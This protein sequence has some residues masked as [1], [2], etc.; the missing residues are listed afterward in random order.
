[1][2]NYE[3]KNENSNIGDEFVNT[4]FEGAVITE[5]G[6]SFGVVSVQRNVFQNSFNATMI[7]KAV[8]PAFNGIPVVLMTL[9]AQG[10]PAY[11]GRS[12]LVLLLENIN[13]KDASWTQIN[14]D[15]DLSNSC[16]MKEEVE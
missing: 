13:I 3:F 2:S 14:A 4:Q 9:D 5:Q 6:K 11:F 15:V 10:Q 16:P 8:L 1:M 12:D 7:I